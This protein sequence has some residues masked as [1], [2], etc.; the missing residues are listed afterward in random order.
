MGLLKRKSDEEEKVVSPTRL[1][2]MSNDD[3][4]LFLETT[5]MNAQQQLSDY[6]RA[7]PEDKLALLKWLESSVSSAEVGVQEM[8]SR[9]S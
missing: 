6:R 5:L 2:V 8:L 7:M 3:V 1:Q 9:N 4:Y